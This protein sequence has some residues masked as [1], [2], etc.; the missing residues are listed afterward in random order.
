MVT[1][2]QVNSGRRVQHRCSAWEPK[3]K[4]ICSVRKVHVMRVG[5]SHLCVCGA[6]GGE[7][8]VTG[9]IVRM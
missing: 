8:S 1:A 2:P 9:S 3:G 7:G 4:D 5:F 6:K